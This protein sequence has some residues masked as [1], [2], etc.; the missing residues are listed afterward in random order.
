MRYMV[1]DAA[2]V[3]YDDDNYNRFHSEMEEIDNST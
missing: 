1:I 3:A 2:A